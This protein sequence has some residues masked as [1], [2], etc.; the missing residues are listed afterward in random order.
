MIRTIILAVALLLAASPAMAQDCATLESDAFFDDIRSALDNIQPDPDRERAFR[1]LQLDGI[2]DTVA[3]ELDMA[4]ELIDVGHAKTVEV[5]GEAVFP[6]LELLRELTE[7]D[8][9]DWAA[10]VLLHTQ[11]FDKQTLSSP[12]ATREAGAALL[13]AIREHAE[14]DHD[15]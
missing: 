12:D 1:Q 2:V 11:L 9:T 4:Y 13:D 7:M 14:G 8:D 3:F 15:E 6:E 10:L 5:I